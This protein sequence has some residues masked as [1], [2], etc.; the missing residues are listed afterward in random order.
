MLHSLFPIFV[1]THILLDSKN[2]LLEETGMVLVL[3]SRKK[4]EKELFQAKYLIEYSTV[5]PRFI[6]SKEKNPI[7]YQT[8][9]G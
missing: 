1:S 6:R 4:N 3:L 9:I 2:T 5:I 8:K 7:L